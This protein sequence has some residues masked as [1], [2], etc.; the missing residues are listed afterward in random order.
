MVVGALYKQIWMLRTPSKS[1]RYVNIYEWIYKWYWIKT[2]LEVIIT[3]AEVQ[4][5][6]LCRL[7][8]EC[9][10]KKTG[11]CAKGIEEV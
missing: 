3:L 1:Y 5:F 2:S 4:T 9:H 7:G 11:T 10:L 6:H 8:I